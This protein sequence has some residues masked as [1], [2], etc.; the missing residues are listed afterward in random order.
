MIKPKLNTIPL[1][2]VGGI[3][4]VHSME[5]ILSEHDAEFISMSRP[6]IRD[7]YTVKKIESGK[8]DRVACEN[9][10]KCLAAIPNN[11][12]TRC[13]NKSWPSKKVIGDNV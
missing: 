11:L 5:K 10:N 7:P 13:Y 9:C 1:L 8:I 2:L 12:P 4:Q 6:F 3:R